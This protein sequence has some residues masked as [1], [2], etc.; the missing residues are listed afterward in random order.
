[1][2]L[3]IITGF[4]LILIL[5]ILCINY[6]ANYESHLEYPSTGAILAEYPENS[7]VYVSGEVTSLNNDG[8]ELQDNYNGKKVRYIIETSKKAGIGDNVQVVG[9]LGPSFNVKS[10]EIIVMKKWSYEFVLL[11]SA[12]ALVFLIFIFFSYWKFDFKIFEFM[13]KK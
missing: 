12:L 5:T 10:T 9:I 1:M 11:R 13:R 8:F 6:N 3:R 2:N 4:I 7:T